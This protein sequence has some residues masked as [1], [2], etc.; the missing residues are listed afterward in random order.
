MVSQIAL[1]TKP[2]ISKAAAADTKHDLANVLPMTDT[3]INGSLT[4]WLSKGLSGYM[5]SYHQQK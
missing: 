2:E 4:Q 1:W 5:S 3:S